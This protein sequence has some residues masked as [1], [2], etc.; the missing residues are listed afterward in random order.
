LSLGS[1]A[2]VAVLAILQSLQ[3]FGV[4]SFLASHYAPYGNVTAVTN[5]RGGSTLGLPI[6]VADLLTFNLALALGLLRSSHLRKLLLALA[7]LFVL[8]VFA[9]GEFSGIIG[10]L[11]GVLAV[12]CV[13]GRVRYLA[14]LPVSL[15]A[16]LTVL[17]P[18][19][20]RRLQGFQST[21]G[22]PASWEGRLQNLNNY[23]LPVLKSHDNW[24]LGVRPAARVTSAKLATGYVWIE[25]GY[26]W[27]LWAGGLPLLGSFFFFLW[28]A[29]REALAVV[30][31]RRDELRAVGIAV[32]AGL[33]VVGVL[34][35]IDPHLTY[36]GSADLLFA[37]L[38]ITAAAPKIAQERVRR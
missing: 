31:A 38:G 5:N 28:A 1:A 7:S 17:K 16:A 35:I 15:V 23:F 21:S 27:L 20:D 18:V 29:W 14:I 30:K 25:S 8:G 13:T 3:K 26:T 19:I 6:A 36:R 9:A 37:L 33:T 32:F 22:L 2:L 11:L 12:A 4:A 34:M 10:L 24:V